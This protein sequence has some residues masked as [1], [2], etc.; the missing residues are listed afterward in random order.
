MYVKTKIKNILLGETEGQMITEELSTYLRAYTTYDDLRVTASIHNVSF[1]LLQ[2]LRNKT[3]SYTETNKQA[4]ES[5][6]EIALNN[7]DRS[8]QLAKEMTA[9]LVNRN[10]CES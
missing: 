9:N 8:S 5:I 1:S 10:L 6:I 4:L 3:A 7:A 2:K